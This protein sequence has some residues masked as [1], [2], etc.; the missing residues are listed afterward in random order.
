MNR[1]SC[2][3]AAI[4]RYQ[5]V[6]YVF[7]RDDKRCAHRELASPMEFQ[8][9]VQRN[10][11]MN[12]GLNYYSMGHFMASIAAEEMRK[13]Q[14]PSRSKSERVSALY[15]LK[16]THL[17]LKS[18]FRELSLSYDLACDTADDFAMKPHF[19]L[20][21]DCFLRMFEAK[22]KNVYFLSYIKGQILAT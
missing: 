15:N 22:R 16:K 1:P 20:R 18:I 21:A 3:H 11:A 4:A 6:D 13:L 8:D 7:S 5:V 9:L 12:C 10:M 17:V 19:P 2:A 14:C